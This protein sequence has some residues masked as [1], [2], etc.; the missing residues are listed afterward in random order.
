MKTGWTVS[1]QFGISLHK[2]DLYILQLIKIFFGGIGNISSHGETKVQYRV[3][4]I[5]ELQVILQHFESFPL[6]TQK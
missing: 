4:S 2:K 5:K 1:L 6:I 3:S